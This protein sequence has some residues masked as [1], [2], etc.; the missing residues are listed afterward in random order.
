ML[1]DLESMIAM[2]ESDKSVLPN[3]YIF[4]NPNTGKVYSVEY[5][6]KQINYFMDKAG[7]PRLKLKDF[8]HS[9]GTLLLS[10]GYSLEEVKEK[11]STLL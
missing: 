3:D 2:S 8:R 5:I 1:A 11:L 4:I 10:N 9:T 7:L 6:R